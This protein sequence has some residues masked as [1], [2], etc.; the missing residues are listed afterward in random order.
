V[1]RAAFCRPFAVPRGALLTFRGIDY[2]SALIN[3]FGC[4]LVAAFLLYVG[5]PDWRPYVVWLAAAA[6]A[7]FAGQRYRLRVTDSGVEWVEFAAWIVPVKRLRYLLDA[8]I[9]FY[10]TLE[11]SEPQGLYVSTVRFADGEVDS[12]CFGPWR[13]AAMASLRERIDAAIRHA[14]ESVPPPAEGLRCRLLAQ[15]LD[16]LDLAGATR[17]AQGR[18]R[19]LTASDRVQVGAIEIP[20]GSILEL[21]GEEYLDP[22]REDRL[23]AA[24]VSDRVRLPSGLEVGP[25]TRIGIAPSGR[26]AY[27]RGALGPLELDGFPVDG[28]APIVFDE[29]GHA[30]VFTLGRDMS[31]GGWNIAAGAHVSSWLDGG[32]YCRLSRP[33]RLAEVELAPGDAVTFDKTRRLEWI[34]PSAPVELGGRKLVGSLRVRRDG[35]I[36]R[37]R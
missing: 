10:E 29:A 20:P 18:V 34:H 13:Q 31:F 27:V 2:Q 12:P 22:R 5:A 3:A 24:T 11:A 6:I 35:R 26:L 1:R 28:N 23:L 21:N 4:A 14:R 17:D 33:L 30:Q 32:W 7:V 36:D 19:T 25:G 37:R 8:K 16:S 15:H 9:D